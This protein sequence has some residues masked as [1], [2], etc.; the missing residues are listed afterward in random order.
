[1]ATSERISMVSFANGFSGGAGG[2]VHLLASSSVDDSLAPADWLMLSRRIPTVIPN[3]SFRDVHRWYRVT[4]VSGRDSS[5][6]AERFTLNGSST[7]QDSN[8]FCNVP[9]NSTG[10]LV[11][12][13]KVLLDGSDW[14]FGFNNAGGLAVNY[15]DASFGDNTF[16]TLVEN[17]V[18][19]TER[20]VR[21]DEL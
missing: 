21:L 1:N 18:S 15:A 16:A 5:G 11:W 6:D 13:L 14:G 9:D 2:V 8:L 7:T 12:R 17:V 10:Q 19:V 4:S 20:S 3:P